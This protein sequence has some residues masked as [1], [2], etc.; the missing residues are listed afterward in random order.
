MMM[1]PI[2]R[3]LLTALL[4]CF[5]AALPTFSWDTLPLYAHCANETGLLGEQALELFTRE[6]VHFVTLEKWHA[7]LAVV[8][9]AQVNHSAEVK[10]AAQGIFGCF[11]SDRSNILCVNPTG[12]ILKGLRP[13]MEVVMYCAAD[14]ARTW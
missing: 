4:F 12:K 5:S 10:M 3:A 1:S 11:T 7:R 6:S 13:S 2:S 8:G 14:Y 9:S